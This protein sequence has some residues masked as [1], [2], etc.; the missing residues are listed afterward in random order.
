MERVAPSRAYLHP[1][2]AML[3]VRRYPQ[4]LGELPC[5]AAFSNTAAVA[6]QPGSACS[7]LGS[8]RT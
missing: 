7:R 5:A 1:P 6:C 4:F 8:A 3:A 2:C